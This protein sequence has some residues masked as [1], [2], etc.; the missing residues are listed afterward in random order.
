MV[1]TGSGKRHSVASIQKRQL[2]LFVHPHQNQS[3]SLIV[4]C[5]TCH[6][7]G[8]APIAARLA[9]IKKWTVLSIEAGKAPNLNSEVIIDLNLLRISKTALSIFVWTFGF[10]ALIQQNQKNFCIL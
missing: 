3:N 2:L 7:E 8:G 6:F 10:I 1:G 5:C 4:F 9:E